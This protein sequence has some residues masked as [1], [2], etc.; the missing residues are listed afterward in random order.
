MKN[1][2]LTALALLL[3]LPGV[4]AEKQPSFKESLINFKI[5]LGAARSSAAALDRLLD[6]NKAALPDLSP[7]LAVGRKMLQDRVAEI[8]KIQA[9]FQA[10]SDYLAKVGGYCKGENVTQVDKAREA[11]ALAVA[12]SRKWGGS[13]ADFGDQAGKKIESARA[14]LGLDQQSQSARAKSLIQELRE[15]TRKIAKTLAPAANQ[16][17]LTKLHRMDSFCK[18]V[19][20]RPA[21]PK[22]PL[23]RKPKKSE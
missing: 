3:A 21:P 7:A 14:Q 4:A 2:A 20:P 19:K 18:A 1:L 11:M 17:S 16:Q 23:G 6:P 12:R 5:A 9:D 13:L 22:D 8:D 10:A 15:K